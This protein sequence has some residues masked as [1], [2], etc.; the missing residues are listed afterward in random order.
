MSSSYDKDLIKNLASRDIV[1]REYL[2][3]RRMLINES[4]VQL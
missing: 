1:I 2:F 3:K 4:V